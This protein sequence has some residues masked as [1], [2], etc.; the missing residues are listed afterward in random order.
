[1]LSLLIRFALLLLVLYLV[2]VVL[3]SFVRSFLSPQSPN[4]QRSREIRG[5]MMKDPVCGMYV[6]VRAALSGRKDG[7]DFYFCSED[8]RKQ[9]LQ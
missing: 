1:M 3:G 9:F 5:V 7:K 6:D 4:R 8:C 2:R